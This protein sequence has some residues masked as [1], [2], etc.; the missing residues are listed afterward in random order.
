MLAVNRYAIGVRFMFGQMQ[1]PE[2]LLLGL[3]AS[4][5]LLLV[6]I[7]APSD[8]PTLCLSS[9]HLLAR[10]DAGLNMMGRAEIWT[11]E[12]TTWLAMIAAMMFPLLLHPVR[13]VALRS[14]P[15]R[16]ARSIAG[17]LLAYTAVWLAAGL[18]ASAI[19]LAVRNF[20]SAIE[21]FGPAAFVGAACWQ[22]SGFRRSA[23]RRCHRTVP[24]APSGL[25]ADLACLRYGSSHGYNCLLACGPGM[26][27][28]LTLS[29][30]LPLCAV[31]AA[32]LFA[33]RGH[34]QSNE[35]LLAALFVCIAAGWSLFALSG[36]FA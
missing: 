35:R 5:W 15:D 25:Q 34:V 28:A 13:H 33:E 19:V 27:A 24:L 11:S 17:F 12:I 30:N 10:L 36:W 21:L 2:Q 3:S 22:F 16:R 18:G 1:A 6:F 14:F 29:H 9:P 7:V 32:F 23:L 4:A 20:S 8:L 26:F 31:L